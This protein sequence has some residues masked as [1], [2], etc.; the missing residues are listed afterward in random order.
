MRLVEEVP[1][2]DT[3]GNTNQVPVGGSTPTTHVN[4]CEYEKGKSRLSERDAIEPQC[5]DVRQE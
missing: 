1:L 3:D 4:V 2:T 5:M